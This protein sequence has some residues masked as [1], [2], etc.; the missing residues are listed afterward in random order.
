MLIRSYKFCHFGAEGQPVS[1]ETIEAEDDVTAVRQA[2]AID[3]PHGGE[4]WIGE[5][6][7]TI[8]RP[9]ATGPEGKTLGLFRADRQPD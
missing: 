9:P 1:A 4:L 5:R 2:R 3:A 7:V 6:R 8:I